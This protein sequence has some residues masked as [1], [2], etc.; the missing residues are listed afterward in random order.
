MIV[1]DESDAPYGQALDSNITMEIDADPIGSSQVPPLEQ[2][3]F[4]Q[5]FQGDNAVVE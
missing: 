1:P 4:W 3:G 2:F 5:V